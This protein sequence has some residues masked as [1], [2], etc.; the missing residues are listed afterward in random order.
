MKLHKNRLEWSVFAASVAI[1]LACVA[2]LA[3][4]AVRSGEEPPDI[5]VEV[6]AATRGAAGYRV[7]VRVR[8]HGDETAEGVTVE[9]GLISGG[10]EIERGEFTVAFLPR[11]SRREGWVVFQRDPACCTLRARALGFEKP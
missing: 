6:G 5:T 3:I 4:S 11:K 2:A 9:V 1:V 8:N 7:P 10:E